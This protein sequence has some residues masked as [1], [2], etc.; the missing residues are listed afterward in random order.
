[1]THTEPASNRAVNLYQRDG[2]RA[3]WEQAQKDA[4]AADCSLSRHVVAV[5]RAHDPDVRRAEQRVIA[6]AYSL[7]NLPTN[8][9]LTPAYRRDLQRAVDTLRQMKAGKRD[10]SENAAS[11]SADHEAERYRMGGDFS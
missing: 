5:L 6:E 3:V 11:A 10:G 1:M 9:V 8:A 2:D 7:C 4:D